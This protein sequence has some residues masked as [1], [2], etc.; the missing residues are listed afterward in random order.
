MLADWQT[1][2]SWSMYNLQEQ[3][4]V[5]SYQHLKEKNNNKLLVLIK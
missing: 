3:V 5:A 4:W 2:M 1:G